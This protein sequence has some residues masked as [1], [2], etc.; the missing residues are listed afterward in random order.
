MRKIKD[1]IETEKNNGR[2]Y[3]NIEKLLDPKTFPET[4]RQ[5]VLSQHTTKLRSALAKKRDNWSDN[6]ERI[7]NPGELENAIKGIEDARARGHAMPELEK[8]LPKT[9]YKETV[10]GAWEEALMKRM[11]MAI[12][13]AGGSHNSD[14]LL[15]HVMSDLARLEKEEGHKFPKLHELL[16]KDKLPKKYFQITTGKED[17]TKEDVVRYILHYYKH[18]TTGYNEAGVAGRVSVLIDL[19]KRARLDSAELQTIAKSAKAYSST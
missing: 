6:E 11:V 8:I 2:T 13:N 16:D 5:N 10:R 9:R 1:I 3:P 19:A 12:Q 15:N 14:F 4:I 18:L 7:Q 17:P